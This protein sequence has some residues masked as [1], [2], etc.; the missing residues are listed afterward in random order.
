MKAKNKYS[1]TKIFFLLFCLTLLSV[2]TGFGQD[3]ALRP[4]QKL[5]DCPT[6]GGPGFH[7]YDFNMRLF[8][9]GSILLGINVG[10]FKRFNLGVF[11][12]GSNIIGFGKP[13]WN[14][15]PGVMVQFRIVNESTAFPAVALGFNNQGYGL[16]DKENER[17]KIKPKGFYAVTGKYF[18]FE[19][20]GDYGL[21]FGINQNPI[22]DEDGR[23]DLWAAVDYNPFQPIVLII[24][25]SAAIND[26]GRKD[27]FSDGAGYFNTGIRWS[28]AERL[29]VD[30]HFRDIFN[31]QKQELRGGDQIGREV[32]V[33]YVE[34]F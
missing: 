18:A 29:A 8:E 2:S 6:A 13:E 10:I 32:L 9:E 28:F 31:S 27:S 5:I 26:H 14:P 17:Y 33:S 34:S 12:G 7:N 22:S 30:I 23:L 20:A 19:K 15:Q 11:Y 3:L 1:V 24:E 4:L 25:Y 21:H 16:Y